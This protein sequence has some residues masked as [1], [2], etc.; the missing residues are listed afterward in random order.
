VESSCELGMNLRI[1]KNVGNYRV[2]AQLVVSGVVLSSTELVS[3]YYLLFVYGAGVEPSLLLL[4]P[5]IGLYP[6][7]MIDGDDCGAISGMNDWQGKPKYSEETCPSAA[8]STTD[9]L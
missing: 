3:C 7:W 6:S 4:R 5:F 2:A 9:P 1:H 8:L